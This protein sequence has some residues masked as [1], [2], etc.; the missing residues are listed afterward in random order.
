MRHI[1][2]VTIVLLP[3]IVFLAF[4][5]LVAQNFALERPAMALSV[6]AL[7]LCSIAFALWSQP[8]RLSGLVAKA[9]LLLACLSLV[10]AYVVFSF[11][12][13]IAGVI[14][15][16]SAAAAI[17]VILPVVLVLVAFEFIRSGAVQFAATAAS[18]AAFAALLSAATA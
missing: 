14:Y 9:L 3:V 16:V 11:G 12:N 18:V 4:N 7:A 13:P 6:A 10:V 5:G 17:R 1:G 8:L 15:W 2:A